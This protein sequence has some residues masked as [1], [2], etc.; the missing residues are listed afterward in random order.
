VT[1]SILN[2]KTVNSTFVWL[3]DR[4]LLNVEPALF[5]RQIFVPVPNRGLDCKRHMLWSFCIQGDKMRGD[6][7]CCY[8]AA[9]GMQQDNDLMKKY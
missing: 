1:Y 8:C 9:E 5:Q 6:C 3:I 2:N 4:L 7:L